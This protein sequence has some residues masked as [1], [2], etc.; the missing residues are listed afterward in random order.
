MKR[1]NFKYI[2]PF[3]LNSI[4]AVIAI[5]LILKG[6]IKIGIFLLIVFIIVL[7]LLKKYSPGILVENK[8]NGP[9]TAKLENG[10]IAVTKIT[11]P[12]N[13]DGIKTY[14]KN[15]TVYK[16]IGGTNVYINKNGSVKA[17]NPISQL[18]IQKITTPPDSCWNEL[19]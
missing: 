10:C 8:F 15:P 17:Y 2:D 4:I 6:N 9:V 12:L 14:T 7:V 3:T 11:T 5:I 1:E 19:F 16:I 13:I 18:S